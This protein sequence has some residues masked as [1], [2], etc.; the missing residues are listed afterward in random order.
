MTL[1]LIFY[2]KLIVKTSNSYSIPMLKV[3]SK[4]LNPT[5]LPS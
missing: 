1:G 2:S 3:K 5:V 4:K